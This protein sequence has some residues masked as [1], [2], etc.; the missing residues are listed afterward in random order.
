MKDAA[1]FASIAPFPWLASVA[2][3]PLGETVCRDTIRHDTTMPWVSRLQQPPI[4]YSAAQEACRKNGTDRQGGRGQGRAG[5]GPES[6][7]AGPGRTMAG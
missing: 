7:G 5:Q 2:G 1:A 4:L 6:P 3:E